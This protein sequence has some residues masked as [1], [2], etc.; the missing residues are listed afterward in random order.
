M[1]TFKNAL[2]TVQLIPIF[3]YINIL[4]DFLFIEEYLSEIDQSKQIP[5]VNALYKY[6]EDHEN[7]KIKMDQLIRNLLKGSDLYGEK[8]NENFDITFVNAMFDYIISSL[9]FEKYGNIYAFLADIFLKAENLQIET[10]LNAIKVNFYNASFENEYGETS[11]LSP[12]SV[13][14]IFK[15]IILSLFPRPKANISLLSLDYVYAQAGS[16]F[17][18]AGRINS[19]YYNDFESHVEILTEENLFDQYLITGHVIET[20]IETDKKNFNLIKAFALPALSYYIFKSKYLFAYES[21]ANLISDLNFWKTAYNQLFQ[22]TTNAFN[23][24]K[25]KLKSGYILNMHMALSS[26]Q[27]SAALAKTFIDQHCT[28]LTLN[29]KESILPVYLFHPTTFQ[30]KDGNPLPNIKEYTKNQINNITELYETYDFQLV[31][32]AFPPSLIEQIN[33]IK[34]VINLLIPSNTVEQGDFS[35]LIHLPYDILEFYFPNNK[36]FNYYLLRREDYSVTLTNE[37]D[38]PERL[39]RESRFHF[40]KL[41]SVVTYTTMK[42]AQEN[43]REFFQN[44]IKY[45]KSRLESYLNFLDNYRGIDKPLK[46]DWWKEFGLSLVP[47]YPCLS[48]TSKKSCSQFYINY[49]DDDEHSLGPLFRAVFFQIATS[50]VIDEIV[51]KRYKYNI[52]ILNALRKFSPSNVSQINAHLSF[53]L[54]HVVQAQ[55]LATLDYTSPVPFR[56]VCYCLI[57]FR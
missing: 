7:S 57:Y 2:E 8:D 14:R 5:I 3:N 36:S 15:D 10:V 50:K 53:H 24:M 29:E 33:N 44:L 52:S 43:L 32:D 41:Y 13:D 4:S 30:C 35:E 31:Q 55:R 22:Y 56:V 11:T 25:D 34:V 23:D 21:M 16:M 40:Q 48:D 18:R 17:L 39:P 49:V 27:S 42:T 38:N 51:P 26:F 12:L 37:A 28:H 46:S 1:D 47:Y 6:L 19:I 9:V 54:Y 45:K 20:L